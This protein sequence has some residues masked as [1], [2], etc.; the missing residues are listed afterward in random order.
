MLPCL[1]MLIDYVQVSLLMKNAH[2][3]T[4]PQSDVVSLDKS[5]E[6]MRN[7][8]EILEL[9]IDKVGNIIVDHNN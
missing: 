3:T 1:I 2:T 7:Q 6:S 4:Q 8:M 9:Q 5:I